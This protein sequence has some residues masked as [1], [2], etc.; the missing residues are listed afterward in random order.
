M[1]LGLPG[2]LARDTLSLALA[3]AG[4]AAAFVALGTGIVLGVL[5]AVSGYS[6]AGW[7]GAGF[8]V[9]M[10]ALLYLVARFRTVLFTV[11]YL[12]VGGGI[13]LAMTTLVMNSGVFETTNNA[14]LALPCTALL[15]VGGA[16]SGS[17]IAIVWAS[18]GYALGEFALVLGSVLVGGDYVPSFAATAAF[19]IVVTT[20]VFD[21]LTRRGNPRRATD[22]LSASLQTRELTVRHEYELRA[23]ARLHDTAL[24]HLVAI[25]DSGSGRVDERLRAGIRQ[26]LGLIIGRDWAL[27]LQSPNA[28]RGASDDSV[29]IATGTAGSRTAT[30]AETAALIATASK[31]EGYPPLRHALAAAANAGLVVNITGELAVL[32]TLSTARSRA[33]DEAVAQCLVNIARHAGVGRADLAVGLGGGEVT[34]AVMDAGVGFNVFDVPRDRIGLRTS[35]RARIEQVQ[36]SVRLWSTEGVGTTIVI[37]VPE[38][39]A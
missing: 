37:T 36:G 30:S 21:G 38:G 35:I 34:V 32:R 1:T 17:V 19:V 24:T 22:L 3:R 12:V 31:A 14:I 13:V 33:V 10:A 4:H 8:A 25:G 2:H 26:D 39:D 27:D 11:A 16:G 7:S 5:I 23:A 9:A 6:P 20:R 28:E 15:L 29:G 18:L